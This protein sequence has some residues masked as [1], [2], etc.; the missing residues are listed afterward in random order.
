MILLSI[1]QIKEYIPANVNL[2]FD[3]VKP[4]IP[5]VIRDVLQNPWLGAD[6][7]EDINERVEADDDSDEFS[8]EL[9]RLTRGV[10][11]NFAMLRAV[12]FLE[13]NIG[14]NG[15]TRVAS[16]HNQT[17]YQGQIA[18]IENS[19]RTEG[20]SLLQELL[21][22]LEE[23][24]GD[25][26]LW[27]DAPGYIEHNRYFF[28][29]SFDF[30][31]YYNLVNG[32][33]TYKSIVPAMR[34]VE[35]FRLRK[36]IGNATLSEWLLKKQNGTPPLTTFEKE[37]MD[38]LKNCIALFS[39]ARAFAEGWIKYSE[40]G[41]Q[42]IIST[43]HVNERSQSDA[44]TLS[45][46]IQN[47]EQQGEDY[48]GALRQYLNDNLSEFPTYASDDSVPKTATVVERRTDIGSIVR[49]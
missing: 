48:L 28:N 34:W 23:E 20:Y 5:G 11:A 17:A 8:V 9:I 32:Y 4:Y 1:E 43:D 38:L 21:T 30:S 19:L 40:Q 42:F 39:V 25:Y 13:V 33:L 44:H 3:T 45:A 29:S 12:P 6:I 31:N 27:I 24:K 36:V 7:I 47:L 22:F 16:D 15:I 35:V 18:R 41:A 2:K 46:V 26:Q 37:A 10:I 49:M 14:D